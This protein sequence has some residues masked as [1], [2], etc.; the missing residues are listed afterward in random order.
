[1]YQLHL[2]AIKEDSMEPG[3]YHRIITSDY[4]H[5]NTQC[6]KIFSRWAEGG[7]GA[8]VCKPRPLVRLHLKALPQWGSYKQQALWICAVWEGMEGGFALQIMLHADLLVTTMHAFSSVLRLG[9]LHRQLK[10]SYT[11]S[12]LKWIRH[13]AERDK[14]VHI[15]LCLSVCMCGVLSYTKL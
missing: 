5:I 12:L 6:F 8:C 15:H 4:L 1:M 9:V 7:W 11:N 14:G 3:P 13:S 10:Q 2:G